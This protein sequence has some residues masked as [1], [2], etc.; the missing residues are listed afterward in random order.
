MSVVNTN[1]ISYHRKKGTSCGIFSKCVNIL[2][3][4]LSLKQVF[5]CLYVKR[6]LSPQAAAACA[7]EEVVR[8]I[9]D[10]YI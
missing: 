5:Y 2:Q 9:N 8:M 4:G 1:L 10:Y 6:L 7:M 3:T